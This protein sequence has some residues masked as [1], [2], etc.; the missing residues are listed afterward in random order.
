LEI[1]NALQNAIKRRH[2][3]PA[4]RDAVIQKLIRLPIATDPD[5][6]EY[7]WTTTLQLAE[8]HQLAVYEASYLE[9]TLRR[10]LP[11]ATRDADLAAAAKTAGA[12]LLPAS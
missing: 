9:L 3:N 6:N 5:T 2:I 10:L 12:I 7:A 4:Y 11:L 1:A 8:V